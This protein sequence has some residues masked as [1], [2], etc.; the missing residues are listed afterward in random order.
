MFRRPEQR[1]HCAEHNVDP[2]QGEKA[3]LTGRP[4]VSSGAAW[5][6]MGAARGNHTAAAPAA[7]LNCP[8]HGGGGRPVAEGLIVVGALHSDEVS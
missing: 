1:I 8:P 3:A 4:I 6:R 2:D 7:M 5:T